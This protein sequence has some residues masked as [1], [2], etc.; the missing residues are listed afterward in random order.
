MAIGRGG[1]GAVV[2]VA[3][4]GPEDVSRVHLHLRRGPDAASVALKDV[5]RF[6]T[7][8]DNERI[9]PSLEAAGADVDRWVPLRARTQIGLAGVIVLHFRTIDAT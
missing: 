7:T 1:R 2:D 9:P 8:I 6:G 4:E 3:I 5:S